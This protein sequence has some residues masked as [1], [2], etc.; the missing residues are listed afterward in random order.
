LVAEADAEI[1]DCIDKQDFMSA[2]L[3]VVI[4]DF[5]SREEISRLLQE[6]GWKDSLNA[7]FLSLIRKQ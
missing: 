1:H 3:A 7:S 5:D 6:S 4:Q 2:N